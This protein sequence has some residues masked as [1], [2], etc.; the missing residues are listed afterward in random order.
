M[1][2][3][4]LGT[5]RV[6]PAFVD[7]LGRGLRDL[8][9]DL[10][11][12][13][14]LQLPLLAFA[15]LS[16]KTA[17]AWHVYGAGSKWA[18]LKLLLRVIPPDLLFLGL[19][20]SL[21]LL[22]RKI[23]LRPSRRARML[24][25]TYIVVIYGA[26]ALG[27]VVHFVNA[28][29]FMYFGAPLSAD[30]LALAPAMLR[31]APNVVNAESTGLVWL[32]LA[33]VT[34]PPL[35]TPLV[36]RSARRRL[37][38]TERSWTRGPWLVVACVAAAG[39]GLATARVTSHRDVALRRLS[40][41]GMFLHVGATAQA[42]AAPLSPEQ[43]QVLDEALGPERTEA[44]AALAPL[45]RQRP[46]VI[47]WVWESVG[48]RFLRSH[49]PLGQADTPRLDAIEASGCVRFSRAYAECPLSVQ[50]DWAL[51]TGM[52]P[53]AN[54]RVFTT[55]LPLPPHGPLL[56]RLLKSADYRTAYISS[57]YLQS[58]GETR[59]LG[60][61]S[62]DLL[63]DADTLANRAKYTYDRWSIAGRAI[64]ERFWEWVDGGSAR[65]PF[66]AILWN[67][68][69]HHP[70]TWV[71]M[72]PAL[73]GVDPLERYLAAIRHTDGLLGEL[74][75]ELRARGLDRNTLIIV[76]GDHGQGFG[77]GEHPHDRFHSLLNTEDD[78]HVPLVF[79]HP[80]LG[81]GC[82]VLDVPTTHADLY[83][84]IA[85]IAGVAVPPDL[86]GASLARPYRPRVLVGRAI[87]WWPL[88]ARAGPY[89]LVQDRAQ[90]PPELYD[91]RT[92]PWEATD[93]SF[94]HASVTD[95][96]LAHLRWEMATRQRDDPSMQLTG[97]VLA[98]LLR[99]A[100]PRPASPTPTPR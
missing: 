20:G 25:F 60:E 19:A 61:A 3:R 72:P 82:R 50:S 73:Q 26:F 52:S 89:K 38:M 88:S 84:T 9:S 21:I 8:A 22:S 28:G 6:V 90:D 43:R 32:T 92:D 16:A 53:P 100:S 69:T 65:R 74:Y 10:P 30:L 57:S 5:R 77:R 75:D 86:D 54:A 13:A 87:T 39:A 59:F 23:P 2:P 66:F 41:V 93:V 33:C 79:L 7:S 45:T 44:A 98:G 64:V 31:Y 55:N 27:A 85:D 95:A 51:V 58:W 78:L 76:V 18:F 14:L 11:L 56:P 42:P 24:V 68:E 40:A 81:P 97:K 36:W 34:V 47:V 62:L 35:V 37:V 71:G 91:L 17:A 48:E 99:G 96:L 15:I 70:Y 49:H 46:N 67:V 94:A 63:E 4:P 12:L 1:P 83:P 80:D 29:F